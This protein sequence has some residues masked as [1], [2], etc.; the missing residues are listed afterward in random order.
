MKYVFVKSTR[1]GNVYIKIHE[2]KDGC[3]SA[4]MTLKGVVFSVRDFIDRAHAEAYFVKR[5]Y[6][7]YKKK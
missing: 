3:V 4:F 2:Y 7:L 1:L 6:D 5:G